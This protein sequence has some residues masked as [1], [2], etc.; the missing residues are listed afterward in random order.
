MPSPSELR[1]LG[2]WV[3]K[4]RSD[5]RLTQWQVAE[6][7]GVAEDTVTNWELNHTEPDVRHL[8]RVIEFIGY[9][10]YVPTHS[11]V[12]RLKQVRRALGFTQKELA[13]VLGMDYSQ[14]H[15]WE[16]GRHRPTK[17]SLKKISD[18]LSAVSS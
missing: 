11:P 5:R 12:E 9:C 16:A 2:D 3:R 7:I 6:I 18:F 13:K 1:T 10:P 15:A 8:P 17:K 14:V 4:R